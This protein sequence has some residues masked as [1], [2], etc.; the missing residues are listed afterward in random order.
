[1][2]K[3][4]I[5]DIDL[6][7]LEVILDK[8][9]RRVDGVNHGRK[10]LRD[11]ENY[12]KIFDKEYCRRENFIEAYNVGF[13]DGLAP[14]LKSLILDGEDIVGY[15]TEAGTLLSNSE[16]DTEAVPEDFYQKV[17][18]VAS[19]KQMFFYDLVPIN[20]IKTSDDKLSLIDL[21]SVYPIEEL[22]H[23]DKHN[24]K[25]KPDFT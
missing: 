17:L 16:F 15:V 14:A 13:F 3:I 11:T 12:Y 21:E 2:K 7:S 8:A 1:M 24:A 4:N 22:F 23:I 25:V 6:N 5:Q 18:E 10:I 19:I 9:G 20:I